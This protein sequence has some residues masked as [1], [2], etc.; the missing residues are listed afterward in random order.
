MAQRVPSIGGGGASDGREGWAAQA[1]AAP[2][3]LLG[4]GAAPPRPPR[5]HALLRRCS[6]RAAF[7]VTVPTPALD[8]RCAGA[9]DA[10]GGAG[11]PAG[12]AEL[13]V[14]RMAAREHRAGEA[15][16]LLSGTGGA[17]SWAPWCTMAGGTMPEA[18]CVCAGAVPS[19]LGSGVVQAGGL[20][21][22]GALGALGG[23]GLG[24]GASLAKSIGAGSALGGSLL[25][26]GA[27]LAFRGRIGWPLMAAQEAELA[28]MKNAALPDLRFL[29]R[30]ANVNIVNVA[31][32]T[33]HAEDSDVDLVHMHGE[34]GAGIQAGGCPSWSWKC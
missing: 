10:S 6:L 18:G 22:I 28:T 15:A 1:A 3:W 16:A 12:P 23:V 4:P 24:A 11:W 2:G 32:S 9:H 5:G 7:L 31:G 33:L 8:R 21:I 34:H 20:A 13:C 29:G 17:G 26:G 27:A 19:A 14:D 25:A 30:D